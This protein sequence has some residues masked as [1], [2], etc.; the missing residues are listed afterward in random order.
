MCAIIMWVWGILGLSCSRK[1]SHRGEWFGPSCLRR[2][3]VKSLVSSLSGMRS[4]SVMSAL[5][6]IG[7]VIQD[8]LS[9]GNLVVPID[10]A[11]IV[12][13]DPDKF[14]CNNLCKQNA[15]R[16]C[17]VPPGFTCVGHLNEVCG[18][19][20]TAVY[21]VMGC[22]VNPAG[23]VDPCMN[24]KPPEKC[25][26]AKNCRCKLIQGNAHC[27]DEPPATKRGD[28]VGSDNC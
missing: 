7:A 10:G 20:I 3:A 4:A 5:L 8:R 9:A 26:K 21:E 15:G 18:E 19:E 13:G 22:E 25:Y 27:V 28:T 11:D 1:N 12:G 17:V 6:L 2:L 14:A 23:G 24:G 16:G